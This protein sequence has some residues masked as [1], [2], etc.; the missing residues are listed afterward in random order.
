M[1]LSI[2][3]TFVSSCLHCCQFE[4]ESNGQVNA[5]CW[6]RW[7]KWLLQ[8][9]CSAWLIFTSHSA[10][11]ENRTKI[12]WSLFLRLD[13]DLFYNFVVTLEA[14]KV[15][16]KNLNTPIMFRILWKTKTA[17]WIKDWIQLAFLFRLTLLST[18]PYYSLHNGQAQPILWKLWVVVSC[19]R[20]S[21][22]FLLFSR[23]IYP[24][25]S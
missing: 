10:S 5:H 1:A 16:Q 6:C 7:G 11:W 13:T 3:S 23:A 15:L 22:L 4:G 19:L 8:E 17:F 20:V 18:L 9:G 2:I 12:R 21:M 14:L 25:S 24:S